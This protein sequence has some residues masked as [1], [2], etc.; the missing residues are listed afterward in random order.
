MTEEKAFTPEDIAKARK[1][2]RKAEKERQWGTL[3][4]CKRC[5]K[6][7]GTLLKRGNDY[8]HKECSI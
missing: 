1:A 6:G 3:I 4:T 5:K 8:I 2:A 7:G